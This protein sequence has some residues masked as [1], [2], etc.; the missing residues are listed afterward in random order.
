M[1][2]L[3]RAASATLHVVLSYSS[4]YRV[5]G[6]LRAPGGDSWYPSCANDI[7]RKTDKMPNRPHPISTAFWTYVIPMIATRAMRIGLAL[8]LL[9]IA[10]LVTTANTLRQ[11]T[12][13][14]AHIERSNPA[15]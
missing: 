3:A 1:N 2:R 5:P 11:A 14:T 13:T 7:S 8:F 6:P 10:G 4:Y 15:R 12:S 9:F